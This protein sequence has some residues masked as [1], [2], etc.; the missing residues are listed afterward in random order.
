[1]SAV[2]PIPNPTSGR[3]LAR[4][5]IWNLVGQLAPMAVALAAIPPLVRGLGL[6][7]FGV[8]S[9]AWVVIGY[10]S[11]FDLGIGRALTKLVAD[12]LGVSEEQA[13]PP[14]VWTALFLMLAL[15]FVGGLVLLAVCPWLVHRVLKV[16]VDL[17][18]ETLHSFYLMAACIPVITVTSGLRGVLEGLQRFRIVNL[19]RIPVS[20]FSLVGPLLVLPFSRSLTWIVAVLVL[21]R[22]MG[23]VAH[24]LACFRAMPALRHTM[25]LER[26]VVKP[27]VIFGGWMT[28][29]NVINPI[30]IYVDRFVIGTMVSVSAIAFYTAPLDIVIRLMVVPGAVAGVMFP[31]FALTLIQDPQ[32]A[33]L[34]LTR[35]LKYVFLAIFP[36]TLVVVT[37]APEGLRFWL[38]AAFAENSSATLRWLS[39][40]VLANSLA[41]IPF[42]L[43]QSAGRPDITAK[44]HLVE[45]PLYLLAVW[46]L[47]GTMGIEG[48][49]IAW[50]GRL[51]LDTLLIG[52]VLE[53]VFCRRSFL[54]KL[55]ATMLVGLLF[56]YIGALPA[57]LPVKLICIS[58]SLIGFA[59]VGWFVVLGPNERVLLLKRSPTS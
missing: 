40:G 26:S 6:P 56:L 48:T 57:T 21:G 22:L 27:V 8:L 34:L 3:L 28:V 29:S 47:T 12:K 42:A 23:L 58:I 2:Q 36:I 5:T 39:A 16:P 45:L 15:G 59:L 54:V 18:G 30:L 31:A 24:L 17:Q 11:L 20:V 38:G 55:G 7:R 49:A 37:L 9:L 10:F 33:Q 19:I 14:L 41:Q 53:R 1:V 46:K 4:N 13:I 50:T 44:L 43:V 52:F 32:R 51:V 25:V 35:S